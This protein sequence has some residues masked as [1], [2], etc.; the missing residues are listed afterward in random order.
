MVLGPHYELYVRRFVHGSQNSVSMVWGPRLAGFAAEA[1]AS[2]T[3]SQRSMHVARRDLRVACQ[4]PHCLTR[5]VC[6]AHK[7][8]TL[9]LIIPCCLTIPILDHRLRCRH[10]P[11]V[12][13]RKGTTFFFI[14]STLALIITSLL[15]MFPLRKTGS[16]HSLFSWRPP[17]SSTC[18][19]CWLSLPLTTP[20][21]VS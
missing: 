20:S 1:P 18:L 15:L 10:G 17:I 16:R 13:D 4:L 19:V 14:G 8:P 2:P 6:V 12:R 3:E 5:G 9:P 7:R 21:D 11:N